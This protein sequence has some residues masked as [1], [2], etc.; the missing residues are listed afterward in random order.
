MIQAIIFDC[1]GVLT[2]DT[3]NQ[4]LGSLPRD[5]DLSALRD[6]RKSYDAGF[7][8]KQDYE[9]QIRE[10]T[11]HDYAETEAD[12]E[13]HKNTQLLA[14]IA[15]LK[16]QYKIGLLSNIGSNWVRDS[17]LTP[18]EQALF[19]AM[20][21]SYEVN[22]NKPSARMYEAILEKLAVT[23]EQAIMVDD[24]QAF[25]EAAESLGM[26]SITYHDFHQCQQDLGTLLRHA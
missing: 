9:Q 10:L 13:M 7:I 17:F 23:P 16:E 25:C 20:V 21:F 4:F 5:V 3:W 14:Y 8:G 1:F 26:K 18:K 24:V 15:T 2:T 19:D 11:G 6:V 12:E 22:A